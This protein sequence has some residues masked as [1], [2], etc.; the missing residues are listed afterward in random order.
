MY[1]GPQ[2]MVALRPRKSVKLGY[3]STKAFW[4]F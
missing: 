1:I 4:L 3:Y 2:V